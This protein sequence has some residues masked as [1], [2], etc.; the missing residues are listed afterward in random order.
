MSNFYDKLKSL[1]LFFHP[2]RTDKNAGNINCSQGSCSYFDL[3]LRHKTDPVLYVQGQV[4]KSSPPWAPLR[5]PQIPG[6]YTYMPYKRGYTPYLILVQLPPFTILFGPALLLIF[7]HFSS[8]YEWNF[9]LFSRLQ[10]IW[11]LQFS[12]IWS[13]SESFLRKLFIKLSHS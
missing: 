10:P 12:E 7:G 6:M 3:P 8:L 2:F 9:K 11:K 5:L 1:A 13:E 4:A